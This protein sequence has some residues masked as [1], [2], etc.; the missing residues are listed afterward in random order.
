VEDISVEQSKPNGSIVTAEVFRSSISNKVNQLK[1]RE[2][3]QGK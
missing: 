3:G 2:N 1:S